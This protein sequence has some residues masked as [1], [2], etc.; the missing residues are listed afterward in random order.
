MVYISY[1]LPQSH[2]IKIALYDS[3]GKEV[4]SVANEKQERGEHLLSLSTGKLQ[5]GIYFVMMNL[6]GEQIVEKLIVNQ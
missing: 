4:M 1:L 5:N 3:S 6:E 2:S